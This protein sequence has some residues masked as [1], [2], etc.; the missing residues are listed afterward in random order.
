MQLLS[1][2]GSL[3]IRGGADN[4]SKTFNILLDDK[5]EVPKEV[6]DLFEVTNCLANMVMLFVPKKIRVMILQE[7]FGGEED[8]NTEEEYDDI[9][10]TFSTDNRQPMPK[11][12]W[13]QLE[14]R[15]PGWWKRQKRWDDS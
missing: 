7:K 12:S 1:I 11:T 9:S 5:G 14:D 15:S 3:F 8:E 2:Y 13:T 10:S 4:L 6:R